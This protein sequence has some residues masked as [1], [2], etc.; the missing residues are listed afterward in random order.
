MEGLHGLAERAL[1]P[2]R[3]REPSLAGTELIANQA[4]T[5]AGWFRGVPKK[6]PEKKPVDVLDDL[7][8]QTPGEE[9]KWFAAA[10]D[11]KL[12]DKAIA[13]ANWTPCSPQTLTRAA[14]DFVDTNPT[15]AL[16]AGVTALRW[17]AQGYGYEITPLDVQ[18][19]Y[20][21]TMKAAQRAGR[22]EEIRR[23]IRRYISKEAARLH[24]GRSWARRWI[25]HEEQGRSTGQQRPRRPR[26]R[27]P[28]AVVREILP[29]LEESVRARVVNALIDHAARSESGWA[30]PSPS[31]KLVLEVQTFAEAAIRTGQADP[32]DV[33]HYLR[34]GVHAFLAKDYAGAFAI[35]RA[36]LLP[37]GNGE[38][39]LGQH[40][41]LDEVLGVD[42]A[43]CA[44][45]YVV[46]IYM[47]SAP[48]KR[49][50]AVLAAIVDA[51]AEG[52]FWTPIHEM[53][54]VAVEPLPGLSDF[55][56]QWRTL[57]V[58]RASKERKDHWE[59]DADRWLSEVTHRLEGT[60]GLAR[61]AR[62]TKRPH[63]LRA[64]CTVLL[65]P[66]TGPARSAPTKKPRRWRRIISYGPNCSM[67]QPWPRNT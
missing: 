17:L 20:T 37:L 9:G 5:Y 1:A 51:R 53:E 42:L 22:A 29:W 49:A 15:F 48:A 33:D 40:E 31:A 43:D 28:R 41:M 13:L 66:G 24:E 23:L 56:T 57:A 11:A 55:L 34:Q 14:R 26:R 39:D 64:W 19:A 8:A 62:K 2:G 18:N 36:L 54:R 50:E 65:T 44:A 10:K 38:V 4:V 25:R 59:D 6:Y 21:F 63:D 16:E 35:F 30:P 67:V 58:A 46:A 7:V 47:T 60:E 45:Q 52:H 61:L 32:E 27:R 3:R 12:F